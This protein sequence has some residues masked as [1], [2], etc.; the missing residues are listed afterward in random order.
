MKYVNT[1]TRA[2][3]DSPCTISGGDWK[4][5]EGKVSENM[6]SEDLKKDAVTEKAQSNGDTPTK[7]EIMKELDAMGIE[8]D[9]K[10]KK[11]ELFELMKGE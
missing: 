10:A 3:I 4:P 2:I 6:K 7:E 11:E 5:V 9:K 1:M 8:Y